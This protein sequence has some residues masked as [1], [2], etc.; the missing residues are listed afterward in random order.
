M[1]GYLILLSE[2]E[3]K[4]HVLVNDMLAAREDATHAKAELQA[5]RMFSL[6][7]PVRIQVKLCIAPGYIT[8][9]HTFSS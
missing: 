9:I 4:N 2:L 8:T 3:T 7:K 1:H 6:Q 5:L